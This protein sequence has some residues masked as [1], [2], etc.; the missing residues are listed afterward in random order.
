MAE[1]DNKVPLPNLDD[2]TVPGE[3]VPSRRTMTPA[4]ARP[5]S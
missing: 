4:R 3:I 1:T 2:A 5:R